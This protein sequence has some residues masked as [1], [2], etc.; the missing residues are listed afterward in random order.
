MTMQASP[1]HSIKGTVYH[2]YKDCTSGNDIE[3]NI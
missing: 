3:K 1:Y 2:I